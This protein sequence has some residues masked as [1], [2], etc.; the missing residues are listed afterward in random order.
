[1]QWSNFVRFERFNRGDGKISSTHSAKDGEYML[2]D[3]DLS[4]SLRNL[5]RLHRTNFVR[6]E[7]LTRVDWK[8]Y[9]NHIE[10]KKR[11][12]EYTPVCSFSSR[13]P[14]QGSNCGASSAHPGRCYPNVC[15]KR[16]P[17]PRIL[18]ARR[19]V[20]PLSPGSRAFGR[21]KPISAACT[22]AAA[23]AGD[24]PRNKN[25]MKDHSDSTTKRWHATR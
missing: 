14:S 11:G 15:G 16:E 23:C 25:I 1:M 22:S 9:A 24:W 10:S 6:F 2:L 19:R 12:P 13:P 3:K 7:R 18:A 4:I 17:R 20:P 21:P 5:H 8:A